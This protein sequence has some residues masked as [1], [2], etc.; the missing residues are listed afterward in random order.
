MVKIQNVLE[1]Q[2]RYDRVMLKNN[3]VLLIDGHKSHLTSAL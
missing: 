2:I 1:R 3:L